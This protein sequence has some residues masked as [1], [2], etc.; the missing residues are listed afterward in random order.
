MLSW[1]E[2]EKKFYKLGAGVLTQSCW[3]LYAF[4]FNFMTVGR[5][6][7][8][9]GADL[10]I[11]L[12]DVI[13]F[14]QALQGS[15]RDFILLWLPMSRAHTRFIQYLIWLHVLFSEIFQTE[16]GNLYASRTIILFS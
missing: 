9:D 7:D 14:V 12:E 2:H 16:L 1:V 6:S 10:N 15:T 4:L 3:E 11:S 13:F 8:C 5:N